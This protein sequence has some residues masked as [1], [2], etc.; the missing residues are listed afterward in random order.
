MIKKVDKSWGWE[1]WFANSNLYCG[2]HLHVEC[3][4]WSSEGRYHYHEIKDETFYVVK[5]RLQLEYVTSNNEFKIII[6]QKGESF[7]IPPLMK[8]RFKALNIAGCDF[9]E[10]STEHYDSD[11]YRVIWD[12]RINEWI[13]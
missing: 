3:G 5:G 4:K 11:S 6:L 12:E 13:H 7:N 2:K 8:H 10:A 1:V 9:I